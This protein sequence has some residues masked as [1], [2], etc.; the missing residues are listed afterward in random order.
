MS[1]NLIYELYQFNSPLITKKRQLEEEINEIETKKTKLTVEMKKV[2]SSYEKFE[3]I[4]NN[5]DKLVEEK[6]DLLLNSEDVLLISVKYE[7]NCDRYACG[8]NDGRYYGIYR[9]LYD[10]N[11]DSER[12]L[13]KEIFNY[14]EFIAKKKYDRKIKKE[15]VNGTDKYSRWATL[16]TQNIYF[17]KK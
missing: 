16:H 17:V 9:V 7:K 11:D 2:S 1:N 13:Q 8:C 10:P 15:C 4:K 5:I 12:N 3:L 6:D 14:L